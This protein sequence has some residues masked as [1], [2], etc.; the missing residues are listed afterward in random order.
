VKTDD[1]NF[2]LPENLIA[3]HPIEKRDESRLMILDKKTG[4]IEHQKFYNIIDLLEKGDTLVLNDTKVIPARL[5]GT[6]DKTDAHIEL[7]LLKNTKNNIWECLVKPAKRVKEGTIISFGDGILKAK[8]I[9]T[10]EEGIRHLEF[11][12]EGV[13]YEIL[14]KLGTMPL[15]P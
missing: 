7:L 11:I 13:F 14:D 9:N 5:F 15:P 1:F 2:D 10:G 4:K 6:K 3:Q 12:F 8:C